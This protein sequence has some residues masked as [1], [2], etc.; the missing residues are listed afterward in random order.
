[1]G[2][3]GSSPSGSTSYFPSFVIISSMKFGIVFKKD[4]SFLRSSP[5]ER[6]AGLKRTMP[7]EFVRPSSAGHELDGSITAVNLCLEISLA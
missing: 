5:A 6:G 3:D 4:K 2:V 7:E 1:M